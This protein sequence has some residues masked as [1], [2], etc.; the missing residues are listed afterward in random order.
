[1]KEPKL[2]KCLCHPN[3]PKDHASTAESWGIMQQIVENA[4]MHALTTWTSKIQKWMKSQDQPSN[5]EQM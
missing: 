5:R 1:M 3:D 2:P 4:K